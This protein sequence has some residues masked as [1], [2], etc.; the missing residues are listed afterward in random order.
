MLNE[1]SKRRQWNKTLQR[2]NKVISHINI[3]NNKMHNWALLCGCKHT[4]Q[5]LCL[6]NAET[7][8]FYCG[9]NFGLRPQRN[10]HIFRNTMEV[11]S[12]FFVFEY[13]DLYH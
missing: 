9:S 5:Q 3:S 8:S 4:F 6:I 11:K 7:D 10:I 12:L 1:T 13:D 2:E